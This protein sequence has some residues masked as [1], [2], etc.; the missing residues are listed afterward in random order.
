MRIFIAQFI[1][2]GGG[3]QEEYM[4]TDFVV[5]GICGTLKTFFFPQEYRDVF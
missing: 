4:T 3:M 2:L 5:L 1:Y